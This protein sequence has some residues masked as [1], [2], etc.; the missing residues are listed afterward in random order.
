MMIGDKG[1]G[2]R[3]LFCLGLVDWIGVWG[4]GADVGFGWGWKRI[5]GGG[6]WSRGRELQCLM[7]W[8]Y[9]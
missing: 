5:W 3:L 9:G 1:V 8:E 4:V 7:W 6:S 2:A